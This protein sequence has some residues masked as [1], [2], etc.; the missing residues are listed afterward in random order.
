MKNYILGLT[1]LVVLGCGQLLAQ[2]PVVTY[3]QAPAPGMAA[4]PVMAPAAPCAP[5]CA[6][7]CAPCAEAQPACVTEHYLKKT[8][9]TCYAC[10]CEPLC[11][12]GPRGLFH[13]GCDCEDGA[14]K[15]YTHKYLIKKVRTCEE[16][17]VRCVPAEAPGCPTGR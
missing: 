16:D 5:A 15:S 11:V 9:K 14:C 12:L 8:P 2:A 7:G 10:G 6:P 1:G 3:M 13:R 4:A 17:A